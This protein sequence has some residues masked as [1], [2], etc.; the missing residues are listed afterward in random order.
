[1]NPSAHK[2]A[3]HR[4]EIARE[5]LRNCRLCPRNCGVDRTAG[6]T[7]Y[8]GLD[9]KLRCFREL[10]F[11]GEE[12][13]LNPSYHICFT[14]CNLRCEFCTVA[15]WNEQ[16]LAAADV[17]YDNL[18]DKITEKTRQGARTLN[19]LGGEPAV[20][21]YG[22]LELLSQVECKT[23]VVWNSN[24]YYYDIVDELTAGLADVYLADLKVGNTHCAGTLLGA[25]DYLNV[26]KRNIVKA[27]AHGRVIVR[28]IILPGHAECCLKPILLWLAQELPG[29][30]VSLRDNYFPPAN[31]MVS[32]AG[33]LGK[34][35][36]QNAMQLAGQLRLNLVK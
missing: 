34:D 12:S 18:K 1:M 8:C 15:E 17:D 4:A 19:L 13:D 11:D 29:V 21:I 20:N 33:Y 3:R 5:A 36:F 22:I 6:E 26:V 27:G 23:T 32:P 9:E 35:E 31:P 16:P 30:E 7:G 2:Q 25:D 10:L 14:G 24:M 28:H